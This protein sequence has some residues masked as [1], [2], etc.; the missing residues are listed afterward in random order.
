[1]FC[2]LVVRLA[3]QTELFSIAGKWGEGGGV[4]EDE[5]DSYGISRNCLTGLRR[6]PHNQGSN[7]QKCWGKGGGG[8][9][10]RVLASKR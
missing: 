9:W 5:D 3:S 10:V 8:S 6:G 1:M 7:G 2:K 4:G